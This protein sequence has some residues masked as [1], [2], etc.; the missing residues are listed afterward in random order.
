MNNEPNS[1]QTNINF[2]FTPLWLVPY[3]A[4]LLLFC[5]M[6]V[7]IAHVFTRPD[8]SEENIMQ[9]EVVFESIEQWRNNQGDI[10]WHMYSEYDSRHFVIIQRRF[11]RSEVSE[12]INYVEVGDLIT[13]YVLRT[14]Y[15][16]F[17]VRRGIRVAG[18][19]QG[20]RVFLDAD[21]SIDYYQ[22]DY[23][24]WIVS[25]CVGFSIVIVLVLLIIA[26]KYKRNK[27]NEQHLTTL[28]L[29]TLLQNSKAE[30]KIFSRWRIYN[31]RGRINVV[32]LS[33]NGLI[34]NEA[35]QLLN[36]QS[37][38]KIEKREAGKCIF[39]LIGK[40]K[41]EIASSPKSARI[42]YRL[43]PVFFDGEIT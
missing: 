27:N 19:R 10:T 1:N 26:L 37:V 43:L 23:Y 29:T 18:I 7:L 11:N 21:I 4:G 8:F 32:T 39:H 30:F 5:I 36:W 38:E 14:H 35:N 22:T 15:E 12:F 3:A 41:I 2:R 9:T 20:D 34:Y 6:F 25:Y 13:L 16:N 24:F 31:L 33:A 40:T 28:S 42:F 17:E